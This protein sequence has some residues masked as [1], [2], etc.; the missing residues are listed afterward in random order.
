MAVNITRRTLAQLLDEARAR[1]DRYEPRAAFGA[2]RGALIIDSGRA[3]CRACDHPT[4][5]ALSPIPG[6]R[7]ARRDP[8][9]VH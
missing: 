4:G 1:V 6:L 3:S 7:T 8:G 2:V 9:T 5:S